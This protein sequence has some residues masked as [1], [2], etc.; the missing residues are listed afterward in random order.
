MTLFAQSLPRVLFVRQDLSSSTR[1]QT[2]APFSG[3]IVVTTRPPGKSQSLPIAL[4]DFTQSRS[5]GVTMATRSGPRPCLLP[6]L[7]RPASVAPLQPLWRPCC[8]SARCIPT[9]GSLFWPF[10]LSRE[11]HPQTWPRLTASSS[12]LCPNLA[13]S[14]RPSPT[15]YKVLPLAPIMQCSNTFCFPISAITL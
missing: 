15:A 1:D 2:H 6:V 5:Q 8:S 12:S 13:L 10:L 3:S 11:S 4:F 14:V 9:L 7:S